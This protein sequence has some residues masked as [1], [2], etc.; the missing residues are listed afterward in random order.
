MTSGLPAITSIHSA[1]MRRFQ[2]WGYSQLLKKAQ[3][4]IRSKQSVEN[5]KNHSIFRHIFLNRIIHSQTH[6]SAIRLDREY[7]FFNGY[8]KF[9]FIIKCI[10]LSYPKLKPPSFFCENETRHGLTL[11]YRSKRRGFVYYVMGQ[12]TQLAK[13]FYNTP[14]EIELLSEEESM[15]MTHVVMKL[16]FDNPA[17]DADREKLVRDT[18]NMPVSSDLFF[19]TFP[20]HIVFNS[21]MSIMSIGS[22][23]AAVM[24]HIVG[25]S[26]DEMFSLT[27]PLIEFTM[28]NVRFR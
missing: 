9:K 13:T 7:R 23:L 26:V 3:C 16:H 1:F 20:F 8:D 11:H 6:V 15:D 24:P 22:G 21:G 19:D 17:F 12:I 18:E 27:R 28:E 5:Q 4:I 2:T 10:F 25:N 14:M